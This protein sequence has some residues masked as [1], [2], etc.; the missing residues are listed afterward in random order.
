MK[1]EAAVQRIVQLVLSVALLCIAALSAQAA[2]TLRLNESL[3]PGSPEA[4]ALAVFKQR[5]EEG[6]KGALKI[7]LFFQDQL[8]NPQTS[9]E[10]LMTGSLDL[11]SGALEY[12]EPLAHAELS[13]ISLAYFIPDFKH[14]QEYLKSPTFQAARD[15]LLARGIRFLE[16]DAK[17]GPYRVIVS[18][19]PILKVQDLQG[20]KL[21]MFPNQT[22]IRSWQNLGTVPLQV[23][24]DQTYLALRQGVVQ[25]VTCP[26]SVVRSMKF[27]EVAPYM[28]AIREYP[29]VWPI[30]ISERVY[31]KLSPAYQKLLGEAAEAAAEVYTEQTKK[32][33]AEDVAAM[34]RDDNAVF[35][36]LNTSPF[37]KK[38]EPFYQK[39]LKEGELNRTVYNTVTAIIAH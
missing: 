37:R 10:N 27:T 29:Q 31:Q 20:L 6:S 36:Q 19:K 28:T 25:A 7:A 33:A 1:W 24:W 14:L 22:A 9:T 11:Y 32:H 39:L 18:T 5:V 34:I 26:L 23:S 8:G 2:Q 13:V 12:Y 17:R 35:I 16:L 30:A 21:R 4:A 15:K 38:M 3:G